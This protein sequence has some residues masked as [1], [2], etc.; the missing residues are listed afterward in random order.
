M[1]SKGVAAHNAAAPFSSGV[2]EEY[3]AFLKGWKQHLG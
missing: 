3:G 2:W 1:F